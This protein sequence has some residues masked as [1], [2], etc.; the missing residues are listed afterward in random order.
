MIINGNG[1]KI[2]WDFVKQLFNKE[3]SEGLRVA[4]KL[5]NRHINYFNEKMNVRLAAQV[6]S[7]SVC[8]ALLYLN[9]T[10]PNFQGCLATAEFCKIF[11]NAF[12][13]LNSRKYLSN[14]SYN[15]S[16]SQITYQK[17]KDFLNNFSTYVQ[18]LT[19]EDGT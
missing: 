16:I 3:N 4:T 2:K 5:T 1:Q 19:F 9:G 13:I 15:S 17:Y 6:L 18:A 8:D 10:D 7:D 14:K 11:N 12:D